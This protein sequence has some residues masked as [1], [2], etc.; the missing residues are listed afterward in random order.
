[1]WT[2]E[3]AGDARA[4]W[5][6]ACASA[7]RRRLRR[8]GLFTARRRRRRGPRTT[9]ERLCPGHPPRS[10]RTQRRSYRVTQPIEAHLGR[11]ELPQRRE[12]DGR[13]RSDLRVERAGREDEESPLSEVEGIEA[14]RILL[15]EEREDVGVGL[16][17]RP[18]GS[19]RARS[20]T[21]GW[22]RCRSK[23]SR[24]GTAPSSG[25][26]RRTSPRERVLRT[27]GRGE[28]IPHAAAGRGR[29]RERRA[30]RRRRREGCCS[31]DPRRPTTRSLGSWCLNRR[32]RK[33]R[34]LRR[35]ACAGHGAG[36]AACP[37][38][39]DPS[40]TARR[41]WV[42]RSPGTRHSSISTAPA[43]T[44]RNHWRPRDD[45]N[46]RPSA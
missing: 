9:H 27:S 2:S 36:E 32:P 37:P 39:A 7:P 16:A 1:M 11:P 40:R 15:G 3:G 17:A 42:D 18:R 30:T 5:R 43:A 34:A 6:L 23:A 38:A 14:G 46:V 31:R 12:P 25:R 22:V 24:A 33:P 4:P 21:R 26:S 35:E 20:T 41:S 29:A 8:S 10:T 44:P 13:L 45:S 19:S 28:P